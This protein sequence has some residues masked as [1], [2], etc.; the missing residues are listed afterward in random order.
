MYEGY[1]E[2][3]NGTGRTHLPLSIRVDLQLTGPGIYHSWGGSQG[4]PYDNGATLGGINHEDQPLTGDWRFW[5]VDAYPY[6]PATPPSYLF[7][8]VTW[9]D[10]H[11]YLDVML[12]YSAY[13]WAD[14]ETST[15]LHSEIASTSPRS[16]VILF[17]SLV[18]TALRT[19]P[20]VSVDLLGGLLQFK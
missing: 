11:T 7:V 19:I 2:A 5:F 10:P 20:M 18:H 4:T 3:V 9:T 1:L 15:W 6:N 14:Y 17:T 16:Q 13:G 8:N 12:Y